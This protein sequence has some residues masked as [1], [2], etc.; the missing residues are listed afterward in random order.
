MFI[1]LS[2][3]VLVAACISLGFKGQ[4]CQTVHVVVEGDVCVHIATATGIPLATLLANNPNIDAACTNIYPGELEYI[5][6][7]EKI[8]NRRQITVDLPLAEVWT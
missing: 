3:P 7:K 5:E 8:Y 1:R 6:N 4:D 2:I